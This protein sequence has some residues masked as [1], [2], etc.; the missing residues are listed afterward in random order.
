MVREEKYFSL[1]HKEKPFLLCTQEE[2]KE[3]M[4]LSLLLA[5]FVLA[6][7]CGA[8]VEKIHLYYANDFRTCVPG[9][10]QHNFDVV[11]DGACHQLFPADPAI[12]LLPCYYRTYTESSTDKLAFIGRCDCEHITSMTGHR[13][14]NRSCSLG[15]V[16]Q[17]SCMDLSG[18]R[19]G[20]TFT[21][22][23]QSEE[24]IRYISLKTSA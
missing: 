12:D 18:V 16:S 19:K 24:R 6:P 7:I 17:D 1:D 9:T 22:F 10:H 2:V 23:F 5:I 4:R 3:N 8:T 14:Y 13:V 15:R 21:R 20:D 11:G